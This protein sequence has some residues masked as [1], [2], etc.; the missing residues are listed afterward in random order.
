MAAHSTPESMMEL[1]TSGLKSDPQ[2]AAERAAFL[3]SLYWASA[4]RDWRR[5]MNRTCLALLAPLAAFLAQPMALA[6]PI[7][8]GTLQ[9]AGV[10]QLRGIAAGTHTLTLQPYA[11]TDG[12]DYFSVTVLELPI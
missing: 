10:T 3:N 1:Q 5:I 11:V 9:F 12:T 4:L 6:D 7:A 2:A 8:F